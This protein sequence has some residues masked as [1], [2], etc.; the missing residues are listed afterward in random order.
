MNAPA[1]HMTKSRNGIAA[2]GGGMS[3]DR[4]AAGWLETSRAVARKFFDD[5]IPGRAAQMSF[6]FFLSIFPVLLVMMATL[7]LFLDAQWIV[8]DALLNRLA[9]VAPSSIVSVLTRL[10]DHLAS[11]SGRPLTWGIPIA[12]WA[13]SNGMVATIRGLNTAYD[14]KDVRPWWKR[15]LVG[16][17]LTLVLM[18]LT[19]AA[20]LLLSYGAPIAEVLARHLALG[21]TFVLAWQVA[22]WPVVFGFVLLAFDLLYHYAPH[23]PNASWQWLRAGTLIAIALWLA[24]SLGLKFYAA[25]LAAYNV[26]YGSMGAVIVLMLWFYLS[27]IAILVGAEV[28][29]RLESAG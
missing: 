8:R 2:Y 15:R 25:N 3:N 4:Q 5:E 9:S 24:A 11:Q 16:L 14:V 17:A 23:R 19:A 28:N 20:M 1:E 21:S 18:L 6:Y 22:Q 29:A 7:G 12:L 26:A 13:A 10:L 27:S